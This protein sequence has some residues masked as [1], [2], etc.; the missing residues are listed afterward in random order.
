MGSSE[1]QI[2]PGFILLEQHVRSPTREKL[3]VLH[4][5]EKVGKDEVGLCVILLLL[6]LLSPKYPREQ[7]HRWKTLCWL[8][9]QRAHGRWLLGLRCLGRI[10]GW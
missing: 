5:G 6:L 9:F 7:L 10:L 2:D 1:K 3:G 4:G 8:E